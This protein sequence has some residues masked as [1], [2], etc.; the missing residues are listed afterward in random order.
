MADSD[1]IIK[2]KEAMW[3]ETLSLSDFSEVRN[4]TKKGFPLPKNVLLFI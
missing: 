2:K 4:R 1:P 3:L